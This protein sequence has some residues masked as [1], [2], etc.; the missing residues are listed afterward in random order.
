MT[1]LRRHEPGSPPRQPPPPL[2]MP[3]P[4]GDK[5]L[6]EPPQGT[7]AEGSF[8]SIPKQPEVEGPDGNGIS[9]DGAGLCS[10]SLPETIPRGESSRELCDKV[11]FH[12]PSIGERRHPAEEPSEP[13][14]QATTNLR[15]TEHL[16]RQLAKD[17]PRVAEADDHEAP[18]GSQSGRGPSLP[19]APANPAGPSLGSGIGPNGSVLDQTIGAGISEGTTMLEGASGQV[20]SSDQS[21]FEFAGALQHTKPIWWPHV[22][23]GL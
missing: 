13:K 20:S 6:P 5:G 9:A 3:G 18:T 11:V 12:P 19:P 23:E 15:G 8:G 22:A 10:K 2:S 4:P 16:R 17:S 21:P 14:V 1:P 7:L